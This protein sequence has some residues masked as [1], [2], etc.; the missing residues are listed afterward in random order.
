MKALVVRYIIVICLTVF[1]SMYNILNFDEKIVQALFTV[2]GVGYSIAISN[3]ISFNS[4]ELLINEYRRKIIKHLKD[5]RNI[6][7]LDFLLASLVFICCLAGPKRVINCYIVK[8]D[9]YTF[10]SV[11]LF[12]SICSLVIGFFSLQS[13]NEEVSNKIA[14]EKSDKIL[15]NRLDQ[16]G[17]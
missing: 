1:L 3:I 15:A 17:K 4:S 8:I 14:K 12:V 5:L 2:L 10:A 9:L 6:N 11:T 16:S 13:L 7:S